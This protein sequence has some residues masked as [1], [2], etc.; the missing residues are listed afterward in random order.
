MTVCPV[1]IGSEYS[2]KKEDGSWE[3]EYHTK[4]YDLTDKAARGV[5]AACCEE[6]SASTVQTQHSNP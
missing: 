2:P 5:S 3:A 4:L 1:Q 6:L